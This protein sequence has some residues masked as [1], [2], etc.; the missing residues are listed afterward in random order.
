MKR[1][2]VFLV[3]TALLLCGCG[4]AGSDREEAAEA[5]VTPSPTSDP[6][7]SAREERLRNAQNGFLWEEGYLYSIDENG[8]YLNRQYRGVLFF[9]EDGRYSS[10]SEELDEKIAAIIAEETDDTMTRFGKLRAMYVYTRDHIRYV[11]LGNHDLSY[12]PAH[13]PDGW[14]IETA[15]YALEYERGNCYHF[16]ALFAALARALGY[17]AYAVGGEIGS[18]DQ[19]HGWIEIIDDSGEIFY[20]DPETEYSYRYWQDKEPDLFYKSKDTI[21][22]ETGLA[23]TQQ[24]D[25]FITEEK[26]TKSIKISEKPAA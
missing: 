5:S 21:G 22:L 23:Y 7:Q 6:E 17:Q 26:T 9:D 25:P 11:G 19:Q 14:M 12:K 15:L 3:V 1:I 16:A 24:C 20:C 18:L 13:G 8:D 2:L 10:G 4:T